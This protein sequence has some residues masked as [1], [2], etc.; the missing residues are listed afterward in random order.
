MA[1]ISNLNNEMIEIDIETTIGGNSYTVQGTSGPTLF[2]LPFSPSVEALTISLKLLA[3]H[4]RSESHIQHGGATV[5][6][7]EAE[8]FLHIL[9]DTLGLVG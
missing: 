9:A 1:E 7:G 3:L 4:E 8:V 5:T 2:V 6:E